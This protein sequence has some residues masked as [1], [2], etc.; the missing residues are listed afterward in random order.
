MIDNKMNFY[1]KIAVYL[2]VILNT[3]ERNIHM[4]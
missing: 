4:I 3:T 1:I 2:G